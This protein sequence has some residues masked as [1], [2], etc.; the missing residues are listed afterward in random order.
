MLDGTKAKQRRQHW[1]MP[2][3]G[4]D[5]S[6]LQLVEGEIVLPGYGE[7]TVKVEYVGLNFADIFTGLGLYAPISS[8]EI[9]GSIVPGLEF[10]GVV[11]R[12]GK[13]DDRRLPDSLRGEDQLRRGG[14]LVELD[15]TIWSRAEESSHQWN[16]GDRVCGCIRFGSYATKINVPAHQIRRIP[17]SWTFAQ[18]AAYTTQ[19][20]ASY[21][22]VKELGNIGKDKVVLV[23]SAAGGCG[24]QALH[25]C[26]K[27][28]AI[29]IATVGRPEKVAILLERFPHLS[30][31]QIIVRSKSGK[32][33]GVQIDKALKFLQKNQENKTRNVTGLDIVLDAILGDYFSSAFERVNP[34]GRYV[35][36]GAAS[37][38]P[39][40]DKLG[41][42]EW[43]TL[44]WQWLQRPKVDPLELPN[45]NVS[46]MGF[47]LI[48]CL[49][50][51][52]VLLG[53]MDEMEELD[54]P[55]PHVGVEF[56]FDDLLSALRLFRSGKT[57]GKVV[58]K[59]N[60]EP[61]SEEVT[62]EDH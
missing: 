48:H 31:E 46:V 7:V 58:L 20:L 1:L 14:Q 36:Y 10:S 27:L 4:G 50:D 12:I 3:G 2:E 11:E 22:A 57:S 17:D 9:K 21:F 28:G 61:N 13:K 30:P 49:N 43:I 34:G 55:P 59:V 54:L 60:N 32:E 25:I 8:G 29:V 52:G 35:V 5:L 41:W 6:C 16:V 45:L 15:A 26:A 44:A 33:F 40:A 53:L 62:I 18:G 37:M 47:N 42:I 56:A 24:M 19:T 38:T 51:I 23:H 39:Q